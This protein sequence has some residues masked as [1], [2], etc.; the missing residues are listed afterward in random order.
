MFKKKILIPINSDL[1]IRNYIRTDSFQKLNKEYSLY[2][3]ANYNIYNRDEVSKLENFCGFYSYKKYEEIRHQRIFNT[4]MWRFRKI[5]TSFVY[6]LKWF[7][8]I[9]FKKKKFLEL[10]IKIFQLIK[11]RIFIQFYGSKIIFPFFKKFYMETTKPN[12]ELENLIIKVKPDIIVVPSQAQCSTDNDI[13]KLA[14]INKIKTAFLVDNW[15]NMS[16]K[17]VMWNKPDYIGVWGEQSKMHALEIQNFDEKK[18]TNLG[19]PRFEHY[20]FKRNEKLKSHFNF[21]YILFLG[22]ALEFDEI[23]ILKILDNFLVQNSEKFKNYKVVYRPHPWRMSKEKIDLNKFKNIL[24]DPQVKDSYLKLENSA[25]FQPDIDYYPSLIQNC[26]FVVGGLTSML[27][28]SLIFY[29]KYIVAA[30][31]EK[32]FNNQN[33]SLRYMV[34]FKELHKVENVSICEN[35]LDLEKE[36]LKCFGNIRT[37]IDRDKIDQ[38]RNFFVYKD[39]RPYSER[40]F[41]Y[42]NR[43]NSDK[44]LEN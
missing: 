19:T 18:I 7:S 38:Q 13:I 31:P 35:K 36:L 39:D 34:H 37:F 24:I 21:N 30:F 23:N 17:S 8:Q 14:K 12:N 5:S 28:E 42:I 44:I 26:D 2:Y 3:I 22:T 6:R 32:R 20:F 33:N 4:L 27:I 10:L 29:K 1:Y 25:A 16:D 40:L 41:E 43:V 9:D 15:D 11:F